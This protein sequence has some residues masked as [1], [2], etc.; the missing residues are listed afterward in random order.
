MM[1]TEKKTKVTVNVDAELYHEYKKVMLNKKTNTT[2]DIVRYM[3]KVVEENTK[4]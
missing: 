2:A 4:E 1:K 3:A